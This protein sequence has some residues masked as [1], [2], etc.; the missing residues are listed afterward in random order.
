MQTMVFSVNTHTHAHMCTHTDLLLNLYKTPDSNQ[1]IFEMFYSSELPYNYIFFALYLLQHIHIHNFLNNPPKS[2]FLLYHFLLSN[3]VSGTK[4]IKV[5]SSNIE[6]D[7][8]N[9]I[10]LK[11]F[12]SINLK[13]K[14]LIQNGQNALLYTPFLNF[15][16]TFKD[17]SYPHLYL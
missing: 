2:S 13:R 5:I 17:L 9:I 6:D 4:M 11:Y 7:V 3:E 1:L 12:G 14:F 8:V 16:N 10:V 15:L